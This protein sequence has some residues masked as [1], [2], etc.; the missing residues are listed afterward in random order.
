[1]EKFTIT[2]SQ[3]YEFNEEQVNELG[4]KA[5]K[6]IQRWCKSMTIDLDY[7]DEDDL[8]K[9]TG[10]DTVLGY[11][12]WIHVVTLDDEEWDLSTSDFIYSLREL[13]NQGLPRDSQQIVNYI[14]PSILDS[15]IQESWFGDI[16]YK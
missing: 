11:G 6:G 10:L 8:I 9:I 5:I 3:L 16:K 2:H 15:I 7:V 13:F 1:M 12:G 14:T 4:A